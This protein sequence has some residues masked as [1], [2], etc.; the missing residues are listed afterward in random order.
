[1]VQ[2]ID[3][4]NPPKPGSVASPLS[5]SSEP[6]AS[7][8]DRDA[9]GD[10][11]DKKED[12]KE[13]ELK[14]LS[15]SSGLQDEF[16]SLAQSCAVSLRHD[17]SLSCMSMLPTSASH[18]SACRFLLFPPQTKNNP[19]RESI[20]SNRQLIFHSYPGP[21]QM[22]YFEHCILPCRTKFRQWSHI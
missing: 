16:A 3:N 11:V 7:S 21:P 9:K 6:R 10:A 1:M 2:G 17:V 14:G 20:S 18:K 19:S 8:G 5:S 22:A 15:K 4:K 12:E 13:D